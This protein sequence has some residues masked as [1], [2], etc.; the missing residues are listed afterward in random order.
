HRYKS[1]DSAEKDYKYEVNAECIRIHEK[2]I[3]SKTVH[4]DAEFSRQDEDEVTTIEVY[5]TMGSTKDVSDNET[6][7]E[8]I[9]ETPTDMNKINNSTQRLVDKGN[10]ENACEIWISSVNGLCI[11]RD[12]EIA[13]EW[14]LKPIRNGHL[15]K[16][17]LE[18]ACEAWSKEVQVLKNIGIRYEVQLTKDH[19]EASDKGIG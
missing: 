17:S 4:D 11:S 14:N 3:K 15:C 16:E 1:G 19:N 2:N 9:R 7:I 12:E 13:F 8:I 6:W 10:L 18:K 5:G